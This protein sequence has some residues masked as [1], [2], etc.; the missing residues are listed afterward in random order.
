MT[1]QTGNN[2][3]T[4]SYG[5]EG[6]ISQGTDTVGRVVSFSYNANHE[7]ASISSGGRS[8]TL[9]YSGNN[10][11]S[12]TDPIGR[13][14]TYEY[15][16]GNPWLVSGVL[17]PTGGETTYSYGSAPVGTEAK[18]YYVTSR[19]V[20][21]SPT[22]LSQSDSLSYNI[23]N[24]DAV[25]S[26]FTMSDGVSIQAY[27]DNN[28]QNSK[29][30]MRVYDKTSSGSVTKIAESDYDTADRGNEPKLLSP[31]T[32]L[33]SSSARSYDNGATSSTAKAASGTKPGSR[34]PTPTPPTRLGRR[35]AP[36]H[37]S[38]RR[39][40]QASTTRLPVYAP[41]RTAWGLPR[42]RPTTGTT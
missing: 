25:W 20:Y 22:Q 8:W 17:Y 35:G 18:T 7:L 19:N 27:Q 33:L 23:L 36:P 9:A 15:H 42:S 13:A 16:T 3:I 14:T 26:N 10:L 38:P 40:R 24:G 39:Y 6:Y 29:N 34:T 2:T 32:A 12:V 11:V 1:D 4:F 41:T 28:F 37:S 31:S 30:L 21:S 5:A